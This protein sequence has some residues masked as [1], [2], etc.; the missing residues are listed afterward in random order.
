MSNYRDVIG[1]SQVMNEMRI[2]EWL[3]KMNLQK[4]TKNFHKEDLKWVY[5][6]KEIK[7]FEKFNIKS[8]GH[9]KRIEG[10]LQGNDVMKRNFQY[11]TN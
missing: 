5:D 1:E 8:L 2:S 7:D 10:V 3:L 4:Y 6:L 9:I 11:L